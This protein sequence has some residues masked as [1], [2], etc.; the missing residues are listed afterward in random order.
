MG[1]GR[2]KLSAGGGVVECF[3]EIEQAATKEQVS[4]DML[5]NQKRCLIRYR[6]RLDGRKSV[7]TGRLETWQNLA[8]KDN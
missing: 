8:R 3:A 7:P 1:S 6:V 5:G 2:N 4:L